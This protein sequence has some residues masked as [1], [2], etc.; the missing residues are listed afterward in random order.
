VRALFKTV[1]D[2]L[3]DPHTPSRPCLTV[4]SIDGEGLAERELRDYVQQQLSMLAARIAACL[5]PD[6]EAGLLPV[7]FNPHLAVPVALVS[8]DRRQLR[9]HVWT[10]ER[11]S[12]E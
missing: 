12:T 8:Y 2:F 6:K 9:V 1:L 3:D 4:G 11:F 5:T 7:E 10:N